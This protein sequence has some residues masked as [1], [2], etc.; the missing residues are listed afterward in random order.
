M[1]RDVAILQAQ[2]ALFNSDSLASHH[3]HHAW[4]RV[5]LK[6]RLVDA[7]YSTTIRSSSSQLVSRLFPMLL[8]CSR[9]E[10]TF[11]HRVI[12]Y[13]HIKPLSKHVSFL[14]IF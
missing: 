5:A 7:A 2:R 1:V 8:S 6:H 4:R 10:H 3:A 13:L 9:E 11:G 12:N 14:F